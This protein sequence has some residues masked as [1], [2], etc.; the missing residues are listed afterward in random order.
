MEKSILNPVST[1]EN[2]NVL[3]SGAIPPNPL[4]LINNGNIDILLKE[5][6]KEYDFVIID[7][8]PSFISALFIPLAIIAALKL[9]KTGFKLGIGYCIGAIIYETLQ[10][11]FGT[12]VFDKM[13]LLVSLV[14]L[15]ILSTTA[16]FV[17]KK[18]KLNY[19][20]RS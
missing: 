7:S 20:N 2:F 15:L 1:N 8:A 14:A 16:F 17:L 9:S 11:K 19:K 5:A 18:R 3:L 4:Y 13:D 12:G 6:R 10:D